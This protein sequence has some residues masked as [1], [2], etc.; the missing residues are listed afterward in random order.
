MKLSLRLRSCQFLR[1]V[2]FACLGCFAVVVPS[3][4]QTTASTGTLSGRVQS[5]ASGRYLP[6]AR[7]TVKGTELVAF[8]DET[9]SYRL[10]HVPAG[11]VT[12][13]AF[14][15]GLAP[16]SAAVSVT[17]GQNTERDFS[18]T[19]KAALEDKSGVVKMDAFVASTSKVTEGEALAT[20]E[21]RFAS[22]IKNVVA[23]DAFGDI[24]EGN[25]AEFMK[26]L[27]GV[28][29]DYSDAMPL[30]IGLRGMDPALTEVAADGGQMANATSTGTTR[31]F[32]FTQA[33]INNIAR[34]EVYK[35]P[36]PAT[37]ASSLSGSVNMVS[38]SAFERSRSAFNYRVYAT[39]TSDG[40][41]LKK[42]PFP[43][44]TYMRRI[45]PGFDFDYTLPVNKNFG[46]VVT[47]SYSEKY[48]EQNIIPKTWNATAA[49]TGA[50]TANPYL[51]SFQ[52]IDA[53]KWY[54][55]ESLGVK[56]DWRVT[57]NSVLSIGTSMNH[58]KD[59]N[60]NNSITFNAGTTATPS[61][62]GGTSLA[63]G[64]DFVRGATGRGA[65]TMTNNLLHLAARTISANIRYRYEDGDWRADVG[66]YA[67]D[68]Q[69]W[70]RYEER[71][72]F[73]NVAIALRNP[74]RVSFEN[75]GDVGPARFRAFDNSNNEVNLYD[76]RNYVLTTANT[77]SAGDLGENVDGG[78]FNVR[79]KLNLFGVPVALQTGAG[80][81][82][83][84]RDRHILNYSFTYNPVVPGDTTP[85]PFAYQVYANR[86]NYFGYDNMP[87]VSPVRAVTAW[88]Q[89]PALFTQTAAQKVTA[90]VNR[91]NGS[92]KMKEAITAGY[93]QG[94]AR[95]FN[96]L[97]VLTGVRYEKVH[98]WGAG[99]L[100]EPNNV[101][102]RNADGSFAHG[103]PTAAN[104][105]GPLIRR[106]EA[107]AV[108]SMEE[109][110]LVRTERGAKS[111]VTYDGYYPS[112]HL[113]FNATSNF[114]LRLAYARTYGRPD[115]TQITPNSTIT[116]ND[117]DPTNTSGVPGTIAVRNVGL[118]PYTA[119]NYDF[120][121]EYYTESG[122]LFTAG[123]FRKDIKN[124]FATVNR[125]ATSADL[126]SI[127][128]TDDF[129]G[130]QLTT[131]QNIGNAHITGGELSVR[132]SLKN[133]GGWAR[134]FSVFANGTKLK[135]DS[136]TTGSFTRFLPLTVNWGATF[137]R[138][139]I[140]VS[141]NWNAR[142]EQNQGASTTQGA[143]ASLYFN[144]A[145][146][147]D[148]NASYQMTK[149]LALFLTGTNVFNKWR[150]YGRYADA[151]PNYARRSQTNSYGSIWSLGVRGTF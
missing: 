130:W 117:V 69:T 21:Q 79:R 29:I 35:V 4:A 150:T 132:Q 118:K 23:T 40:M 91:I 127:G 15:S 147:M 12:I 67:S 39:T 42:Q 63:Y 92:D 5:E 143:D 145:V 94:E 9:G 87:F 108:G 36:T 146:V 129:L 149:R 77:T 7:V 126:E 78:D 124:F 140:S 51:Q 136:A 24:A 17:A 16:L 48:N 43:F 123:V 32:D 50:T 107:G 53:P 142:G 74:V 37:S 6:N 109:L 58:Y 70:R 49:G 139:P 61:V 141:V 135:L 89:N 82:E 68:S 45:K 27:P 64:P 55:R 28:A 116:V 137:S 1:V 119:N 95:F 57:R 120:S 34:I 41:Q 3:F 11:S 65:V 125:P 80:K 8:T 13:E 90:E 106:P 73:Q 62:T 31:K 98:D 100:I 133:L 76:L 52:V 22:N 115:F 103:T 151:T 10:S 101:Y 112:I 128:F 102:V 60:G 99:A 114:T 144:P 18:L 72:H 110:R 33:S 14:Y 96:R 75:I 71:G 138:S 113:N 38:K 30:S 2:L 81:K 84:Y 19:A 97:Q 111:N 93:L 88:R 104:P 134:Y 85:L 20:N 59:F 54:E 66:I 25:V 86:P 122:G 148:M 46:L 131:T 105:R 83:Q 56:A 121:A 47:G 44:E 26:F